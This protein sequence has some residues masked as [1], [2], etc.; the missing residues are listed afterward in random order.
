MFRHISLLLIICTPL[1]LSGCAS[2]P[3]TA[4]VSAG[5]VA[6]SVTEQQF[7]DRPLIP[8]PAY[9]ARP[10]VVAVPAFPGNQYRL[11][12][13]GYPAPLPTGVADDPATDGIENPNAT[14]GQDRFKARLDIKNKYKLLP[15]AQ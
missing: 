3:I 11:R 8:R 1:A 4:A 9:A 12:F 6:G 14:Q 2:V 15:D 5:A 7:H 10:A 13:Q